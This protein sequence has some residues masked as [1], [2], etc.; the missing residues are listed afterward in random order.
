MKVVTY[1]E[2]ISDRDT[3]H[4]DALLDRWAKSWAA[5]GWE[6]EVV[7]K[8]ETEAHPDCGWLTNGFGSQPT[9]NRPDYELACWRR[10][11]AFARFNEPVV[12]SDYDVRNHGWAPPTARP[13]AA[14]LDPDAL[15]SCVLMSPRFMQAIPYLL[16]TASQHSSTS[17]DGRP[18]N[19]DMFAWKWLS[20]H[21]ARV[22]EIWPVMVGYPSAGPLVHYA[23]AFTGS[24][25]L[26]KVAAWDKG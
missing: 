1:F 6:P 4:E 16:L 17:V 22:F 19:S 10:W 3:A 14:S 25:G 20:W 24:V 2:T 18:H 21:N 9:V 7:G 15:S 26:T 12:V 8:R 23:G 13:I 11:L 5:A